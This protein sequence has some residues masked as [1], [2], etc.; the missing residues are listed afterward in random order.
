MTTDLRIVGVNHEFAAIVN[1]QLAVGHNFSPYHIESR[2]AVCLVGSEIAQQLF[3]G[4]QPL[5]Q[6]VFVQGG[7]A[8]FG[9]R[10]IGFRAAPGAAACGAVATCCP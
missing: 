9:C 1:R 5:G 4:T 8:A 6:I 2:A 7:K 3:A 10:V